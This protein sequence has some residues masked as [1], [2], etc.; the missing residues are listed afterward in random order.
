MFIKLQVIAYTWTK[1]NKIHSLTL[2]TK[3][4]KIHKGINTEMCINTCVCVCL[5]MERERGET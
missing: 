4:E 1:K 3:Q 5:C 2:G